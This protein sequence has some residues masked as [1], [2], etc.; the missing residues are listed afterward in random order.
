G[1]HLG[2]FGEDQVTLV[3][4]D[5]GVH[6]GKNMTGRLAPPSTI[7]LRD[8]RQE[9]ERVLDTTKPRTGRGFVGRREP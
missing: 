4:S 6:A 9:A 1:H 2:A 8:Y 7:D 5:A 3:E